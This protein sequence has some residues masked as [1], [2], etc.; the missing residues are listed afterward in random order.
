MNA[1]DRAE[2]LA[3]RRSGIGGSDISA[4][5][6]QNPYKTGLQLWMDKTG[7]STDEPDGDALERMH[8][9]TVLEDVV[10]RHYAEQRGVKVQRINDQ[11]QHPKCPVAIAN[12]DRAVIEDGTRAR[13]DGQAGRVL[14]A[15][16]VLECKT[17]HAMAQHS[18]D[19]GQ[20]G[21]DE[22]PQAYWLQCQWYLGITG[23]PFADLAV[24]FGGQKFEIYTIA[25][26]AA[27][28]GDMLTEA[29]Q[30]WQAHVVADIPPQPTT[31]DEARRL[32]K[33]HIAGRE[34]IVD[35]NTATAVAELRDLKAQIKALEAREQAL[36]DCITVACG[37]AE[38]ISYMGQR[39]AT[40][41]QNK[42]GSKIDWKSAFEDAA[43]RLD[44]E[45][46]ALV[47]D[48]YTTPTEGARVLRIAASKE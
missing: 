32:W 34:K 5:L 3:R 47:R 31:E 7:R 17:A 38:Y 15:R 12:I 36:R 26:D 44:P 16:N 45:I 2:F 35:A 11:M 4:I 22:V 13:W 25:A 8:W 33:S 24:L 42:P 19:W 41:K 10:A 29:E 9:G 43:G 18:A 28:F 39:L 1:P 30:W 27:L 40:W 23:L 46:V 14:G 21:T 37:E 20:P 48:Q 6:G